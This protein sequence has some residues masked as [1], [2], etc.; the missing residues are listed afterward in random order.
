MEIENGSENDHH[1][2]AAAAGHGD[3][4]S[5][6]IS[7]LSKSL[8]N[9][10]IKVPL[11]PDVAG[12]RKKSKAKRLTRQGSRDGVLNGAAA[13]ITYVA[14]ERRWK[15]SR[16]SRNGYGRGLPKKGGAGGKGVWGKMGSEL[17]V[18]ED[19]EDQNDPNYENEVIDRNTELK[20][21]V[22]EPTP[23][24]F[25]KLVEPI[26]LE[27]FENGDT[28]EVAISLDEI[29]VSSNLRQLV[30]SVAIEISMDHK[31]SQREMISLLI[32]DLY[33]KVVTPKDIQKGK[34]FFI[35]ILCNYING[36]FVDKISCFDDECVFICLCFAF[37]I[38][39]FFFYFV[40]FLAIC[41]YY[42]FF[43]FL[44]SCDQSQI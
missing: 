11:H 13:A 34:F 38:Y 23:E 30:T 41:C 44:I 39:L 24:E 32:S 8:P 18:E 43:V 26:I 7:D 15:N 22:L 21:I 19:V 42:F 2:L 4:S 33:G 20:E 14:P 40:I 9:D 6:L 1:G 31:D 25:F 3:D 5:K 17:L 37:V 16:R 10:G 27:Y 35:Y 29:V 28:H 36:G 12:I